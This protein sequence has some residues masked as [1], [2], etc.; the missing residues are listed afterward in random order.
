MSGF[1]GWFDSLTGVLYGLQSL[2]V[3]GIGIYLVSGR[4]KARTMVQVPGRWQRIGLTAFAIVG[5]ALIVFGFVVNPE[6]LATAAL[7]PNMVGVWILLQFR[8][9]DGRF[10][11]T[12]QWTTTLPL[13]A[14]MD[15]LTDAFRQP[16]LR[17][18]TVGQDVWIEIRKEWAGG[19]W[20]H[21]DAARHMKTVPGVHFRIDEID[22]GT[23]ITAHSGEQTALGKYD[24]LKLSDEMSASAVELAKQVTVLAE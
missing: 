20:L 19:T 1:D 6:T 10:Q 12:E 3:L 22:G 4:G 11:H 2:F 17:A 15:S 14:A 7:W 8:S 16:G 18:R 13:D 24:V 5:T 23:R 9:I 21:E